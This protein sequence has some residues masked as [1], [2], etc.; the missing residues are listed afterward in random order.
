MVRLL[1][2]GI[3]AARNNAWLLKVKRN[4]PRSLGTLG[5]QRSAL[6][7]QLGTDDSCQKTS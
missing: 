1:Y 7:D 6:S 3:Y 5:F 4:A 2:G